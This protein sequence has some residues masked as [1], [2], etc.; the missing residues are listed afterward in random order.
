MLA[1]DVQLTI[2][3]FAKGYMSPSVLA[4]MLTALQVNTLV[5]MNI[6]PESILKAK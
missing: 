6:D 4:F 1:L 5:I 3:T 2:F